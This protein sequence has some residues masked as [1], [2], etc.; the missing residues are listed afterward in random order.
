[1]TQR[2][3][4]MKWCSHLWSH[5]SHV[6]YEYSQAGNPTPHVVCLWSFDSDEHLPH[7]FASLQCDQ[8]LQIGYKVG[9][10]FSVTAFLIQYICDT[11]SHP[12]SAD[13][14]MN[15][16][17]LHTSDPNFSFPALMFIKHLLGPFVLK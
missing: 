9:L 4:G 3:D 15:S 6:L 7:A 17:L 8:Q 13:I 12:K 1:M 2:D 10:F 16:I 14:Y 11:V 5:F